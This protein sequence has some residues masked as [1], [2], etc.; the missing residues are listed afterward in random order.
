MYRLRYLHA[1][2][3]FFLLCPPVADGGEH[4]VSKWVGEGGGTDLPLL[5]NCC[6]GNDITIMPLILIS[7]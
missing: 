7:P 3:A 2:R 1:M 6:P 4:R 5:R